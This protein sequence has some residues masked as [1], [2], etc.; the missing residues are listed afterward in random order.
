MLKEL[1]YFF[2]L[3]FIV[4]FFAMTAKFYFSNVNIKK[5]FRAI[6]LN[7]DKIESYSKKIPIL[8]NDTTNIIEY[9]ESNLN[10]NKKKYNFWKLLNINE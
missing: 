7:D 2:F 9:K 4:F 5:S 1:K 8:K 6:E 3:F 10:K